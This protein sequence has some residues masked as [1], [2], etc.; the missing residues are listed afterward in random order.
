MPIKPCLR[1][2]W[3]IKLE[4]W[5]ASGLSGTAWCGENNISYHVFLYWRRKLENKKSAA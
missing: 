1:E 3:K 4:Q 2:E 5:H